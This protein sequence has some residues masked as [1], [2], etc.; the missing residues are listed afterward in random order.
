MKVFLTGITEVEPKLLDD[1]HKFLSR[2]G[3]PIEY[4]NLGVSDHSG[5]KTIFPEV[6]DFD[7]Q[8]EF[9]F[10]AAI[11][12][13]QLLK[14]KEDIPQ[15]DILVV[16]TK[17]E[18]GAPIEEFKT[19]FSYFDDNVIIVRDKE[20]DFFPKSKW[21]FVLSHQVVEN[22]FQIF[23][24]ASMKEAPKFS[25]MTPKGC[26]N[27]FCSTPPQIEFKL[28]MAHIC[29]ECLNRANSYN[30]DPNVLRQIK[31]TIESVRTKLDNFAD[32]VSI[33]EFSPVVVSEKGEILIEDKE[34]HLQDLPKALYLFFLKNPGVSIQNQY[35]RNYKDDLVRIYSKIKRGGEN[36]P[37]YK[38]LGF[39]ERGEK[40]VGYLNTEALKNHRYNIS[41]ELKS[42]LGE[43]KTEF[44]Q[45][46]SWR[47]KVNNMPQFYNQIGIPEDLIQIPHNF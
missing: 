39:D 32:S 1:I 22:L 17:K 11:K 47:K 2:I 25:H 44:Y 13:G 46:K 38:L 8:D 10:G 16:F 43:A 21:P 24:W 20:L 45:I 5:F 6:K 29:N 3:G 34:I 31:D 19:W 27:D 40:T 4:H 18:L 15:E 36:G 7:A 26:L 28:R 37:L 35:L 33:E 12:F 42:K 30:I 14:F 41:K 23:S 9:D